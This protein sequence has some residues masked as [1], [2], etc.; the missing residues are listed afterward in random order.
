[1]SGVMDKVKAKVDQVMHKDKT[2][3]KHFLQTA[4]GLKTTMIPPVLTALILPT[5]PILLYLILPMLPLAL[6]ASPVPTMALV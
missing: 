5:L 6:G 4:E 2:H 1:M 3:G